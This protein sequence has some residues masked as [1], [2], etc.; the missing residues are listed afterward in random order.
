M[1]AERLK[2]FLISHIR[3]QMIF[4]KSDDRRCYSKPKF[5]L[6][7]VAFDLRRKI[8]LSSNALSSEW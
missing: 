8:D 6:G 1:E 5:K 3:A 7:M 4:D 2:Y